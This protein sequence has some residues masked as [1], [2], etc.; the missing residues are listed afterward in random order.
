VGGKEKGWNL[1]NW[2]EGVVFGYGDEA[3]TRETRGTVGSGNPLSK[4]KTWNHLTVNIEQ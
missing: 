2:R 1:E 4:G 3:K